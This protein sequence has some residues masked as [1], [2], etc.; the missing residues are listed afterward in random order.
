MKKRL[1]LYTTLIIFTGILCFFGL[2]VHV[3]YTGN[4]NLAKDMVTETT[5]ICAGLY[6]EDTDL[7]AFVKAGGDTR[8]TVI[9]KEGAVL[10]DSR[11]IDLQS[12][13]NHLARPEI[14]AALNDS[15][16]AF[17]RYSDT[18]GTE[19]IYYALKVQDGDGYVFIRAAVP[20]A[21]VNGY[22]RQT[23]PILVCILILT[24]VFCL[25]TARGVI[26]R[27]VRPFE[28]VEQ[29][30]ISLSNGEYAPRPVS[31]R[32]S[33]TDDL[34][35]E[36]DEIAQ[37]LQNSITA[38]QDETNKAEYIFNNIA[39][40]LFAVDENK[41]IVLVNSAALGIFDA[42]PE[43]KGKNLNYMTYDKT[44]YGAVDDC[45]KFGKSTLFEFVS[46]GRIFLAAVKQLHDTDLTMVVLSD[47]TENRENSKRREEFFSNASHELKTP[48]TAI[49]GFNELTS[50]NNKDKSLDKYISGITRETDRMLSLIGD[51][52]KLSELET[53]REINP[54]SVSL[55]GTVSEARE[56]LSTSMSE[57]SISFEQTGDAEVSAEPE[58]LYNLVKNL[59]ENAVR[60]G[61]RGGRVSVTMESDGKNAWLFVFDDGAGISPEEQTRIFERFYRAEKSRS[62]QNGGTGLGLSIVKHIC[63][64]YDWKLSLKSKL[65]VGTEVT[66]VFGPQ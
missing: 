35:R 58:H 30:L 19:L 55:A 7:S 40:G 51:M 17:V 3:T 24:A 23:V 1:Y 34:I 66:V 63:A 32:R 50:L 57:K 4:L 21:A 22:L 16:A 18:L 41:N 64:L 47:V 52:L 27:L 31:R 15:P 45:V 59:I 12:S 25:F 13:E 39:D 43:I 28:Y 6:N 46:G 10:A 49:K 60:Y 11:P 44:L 62:Q 56:T 20:V 26:A 29:R 38:L 9:S 36:T 42:K 53:A 8:I 2:S 5:R 33:E 65:G 61:N 54:V 14:Q 37:I 48:L